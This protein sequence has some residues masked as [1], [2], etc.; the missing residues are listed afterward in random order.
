[1]LVS[2]VITSLVNL[3]SEEQRSTK[4]PGATLPRPLLM[5]VPPGRKPF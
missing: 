3:T 2:G 4:V 1:M 5:P